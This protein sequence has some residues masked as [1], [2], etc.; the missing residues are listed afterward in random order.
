MGNTSKIMVNHGIAH[1]VVAI[2]GHPPFGKPDTRTLTPW[3]FRGTAST[4]TWTF[5][6]LHLR[7]PDKSFIFIY[8]VVSPNVS[9]DLK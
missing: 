9:N 1:W 2:W 8:N 3:V 6:Q 7:M 4:G 5:T